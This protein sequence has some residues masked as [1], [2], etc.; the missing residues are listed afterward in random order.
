MTTQVGS[1]LRTGAHV[2]RGDRQRHGL[3][4]VH[5]NSSLVH[6]AKFDVAEAGQV[7]CIVMMPW[8]TSTSIPRSATDCIGAAGNAT[9]KNGRG[10]TEVPARA[11]RADLRHPFTT[12]VL[13]PCDIATLANEAPGA[14]HSPSTWK[15]KSAPVHGLNRR[16]DA[17]LALA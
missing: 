4:P 10:D 5:R 1:R 2:Q 15:L 16:S 13:M 17:N 14:S 8:C 3:D 6:A 12:W 9:A 7:I 11:P